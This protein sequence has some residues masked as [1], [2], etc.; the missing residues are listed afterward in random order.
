MRQIGIPR[1]VKAAILLLL[2]DFVGQMQISPLIHANRGYLVGVVFLSFFLSFSLS[3][4]V[5]DL[6]ERLRAVWREL[7]SVYPRHMLTNWLLVMHGW[8]RISSL[9]TAA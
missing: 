4:F 2:Q 3:F 1:C 6:H 5:G 8:L 9:G 7:D